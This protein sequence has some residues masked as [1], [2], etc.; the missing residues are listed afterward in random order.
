M[1]II[2]TTLG[3][4][5]RIPS[6]KICSCFFFFF[7]FPAT[8]ISSSSFLPPQMICSLDFVYFLYFLFYQ[9]N[10]QAEILSSSLLLLLPCYHCHRHLLFSSFIF[11]LPLCHPSFRLPP[12]LA[13]LVLQLCL[14]FNFFK[15]LFRQK[16][17]R[18][19]Y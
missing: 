3:T 11:S 16:S 2:E 10:Y 17:R 7:Y 5:F 13:M 4:H 12:P 8:S 18:M 6:R 9:I 14:Y 19:Y 15:C 1:A